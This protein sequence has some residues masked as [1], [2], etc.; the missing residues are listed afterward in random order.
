MRVL[1]AKQIKPYKAKAKRKIFK[2]AFKAFIFIVL[3]TGIALFLT[4]RQGLKKSITIQQSSTSTV[5]IA[6]SPETIAQKP[7]KKL[8]G[9]GFKKLFQSV[10]YPNTQ[11]IIDPPII[12]GDTSADARIRSRA[13]ARGYQLSRI[14]MGSIVK[15]KDESRL[16]SDDLLQPLA[17]D[18]WYKV[19]QAAKNEGYSLSLISAY[20]SPE[21]Q[22]GM[23]ISRIYDSGVTLAQLANGSADTTIDSILQITAV[24]GYSRHHT[25]YTVDFWCN[26]GSATFLA[27]S[28]YRWLSANSYQKAME[29]GWIPSY[30]EGASEQGPEPEPWE[31]VWVG[32]AVRQL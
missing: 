24:P 16:D 22:R 26:D 2:K 13:E 31:Y 29:Y 20:R 7:L 1:E 9:D 10:A 8:S 17:A 19:K 3:V 12:T 30:P 14:P 18:A 27:S 32:N 6:E 11:E 23:F 25:G 4:K 28:C 5:E 21:Y 15:I